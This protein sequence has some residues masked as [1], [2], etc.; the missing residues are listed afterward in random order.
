M[1]VRNP[2]TVLTYG[3][4]KYNKMCKDYCKWLKYACLLLRTHRGDR[5]EVKKKFHD[6]TPIMELL[7]FEKTIRI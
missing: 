4:Q 2:I 5:Q 6:N 1:V 3:V 7:L